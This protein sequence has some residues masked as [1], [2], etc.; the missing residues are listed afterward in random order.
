[1]AHNR[2]LLALLLFLGMGLLSPLPG[3]CD[4]SPPEAPSKI[5]KFGIFPYTSPKT[6]FKLFLPL[7]HKLE[8]ELQCKIELVTAP[9]FV[10]FIERAQQG[11]YDLTIPCVACYFKIRTAGYSVIAMGQPSFYGAVIVRSDSERDSID[12]LVGAKVASTVHYSYAGHLFLVEQLDALG[13]DAY[14]SIDF[15]F[16]GK[17]DSIIFGV[18]NKEYDAG[19]I[20]LDAISAPRFGKIRDKLKVISRSREIP[21][22]PV[23]VKNTLTPEQTEII[24]RTLVSMTPADPESAPI[25]KSLQLNS[26]IPANDKDYEG[27]MDLLK[28]IDTK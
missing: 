11:E 10:T 13:I 21:Q 14:Q 1:M 2:Y 26:F 7:T 15:H 22:F 23:A 17:L 9:E 16:I 6:I 5:L 3:D 25:L 27:I 24:L 28:K 18:V 20:R 4:S 12:K 19:M 8:E